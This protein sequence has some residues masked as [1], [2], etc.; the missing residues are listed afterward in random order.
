MYGSEA[1]EQDVKGGDQD[2]RD[3]AFGQ[4]FEILGEAAIPSQPGECPL[5]DPPS[6]LELEPALLRRCADNGHAPPELL[7][8]PIFEAAPIAPI[9]PQVRDAGKFLR[10]ADQEIPSTITVL[11]IGR[12]DMHTEEQSVGVHQ[13]M[14]LAPLHLFS[15]HRSRGLRPLP[16][17]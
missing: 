12:V 7:L 14:A 9:C 2:V 16:S 10:C 3:D 11:L 6:D 5:Y 8:D 15:P 17:S 1:L 4:F 13:D